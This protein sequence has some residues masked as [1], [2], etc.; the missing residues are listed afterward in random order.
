M[1]YH[2][3][4]T[5]DT[6]KSKTDETKEVYRSERSQTFYGIDSTYD[7]GP[8]VHPDLTSRMSILNKGDRKIQTLFTLLRPFVD[9]Y[10]HGS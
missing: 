9:G 8:R 3:K 5:R 10:C 7:K 4:R 1:F 6:R 2:G